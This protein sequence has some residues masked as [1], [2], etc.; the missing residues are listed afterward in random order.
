M[1]NN[2]Y[3]LVLTGDVLPGFTP[4][5]VW[6]QLAAHFR[7]EPQKLTE[8]LARTPR[9]VKQGNDLGKLQ[10][11][12]EGIMRTGAKAEIC[13]PDIRPQ[14][15]ALVDGAPR[16]PVPHAL[17][18]QRVKQ[19]LWDASV[20]VAEVGASEWKPFRDPS[21]MAAEP[22]QP[23]PAPDSFANRWTPPAAPLVAEGN[24]LA[25]TGGWDDL[26]AGG[27]IHAGFWRRCA[28][29]MLDSLVIVIPTMMVNIVPFIGF[30]LGIVGQ[31]LYCAL[32]ESSSW[33]ATLG[34]H[35]MGIK[36]VDKHGQRI[37]FGHATGRHFGKILSS[38]I[39]SVGYMMAGWTERK[40][41][42]HDLMAGTFVVFDA[43]QPSQPLPE[44]RPPMPWYGWVLN[45]A[46]PLFF[47]I[48]VT[49]I[50]AAIALP[51]Y[52]DYMV[53]TKMIGVIASAEPVKAEVA[54]QGCQAKSH[55]SSNPWVGK[56]EVGS[57]DSSSCTIVLTLGEA[58]DIPA[59][60]RGGAI[61]LTRDKGGDW[62]CSSSLPNK[63]LP[64][65]CRE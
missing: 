38:L 1:A 48:A 42:L 61:E 4:E 49:G 13:T 41:G 2:S 33:Q 37:G 40:Q 12:Q 46:P 25:G 9:I 18:E 39:F 27:A 54:S 10:S 55:A 51:A 44:Q 24:T 6:P 43:V 35:A 28:A 30:I 8:F 20:S 45:V 34:K 64:A 16:G 11:L 21:A 60:L 36:V 53:R 56:V 52:Q 14:L 59:P 23:E 19:G 31:W 63:Y 17:V 32:M 3:A 47:L 22:Q 7:M 26:P 15:Y 65:T 62:A 5:A 58:K 29:L 57:D 50:L